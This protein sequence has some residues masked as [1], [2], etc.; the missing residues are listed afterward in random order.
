[1]RKQLAG[2]VNASHTPPPCRHKP[3]FSSLL[4]LVKPDWLRG[5]IAF[6]RTVS[7]NLAFL[8]NKKTLNELGNPLGKKFLDK[9]KSVKRKIRKAIAKSGAQMLGNLLRDGKPIFKLDKS[10]D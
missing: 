5:Q 3:C 6:D 1:D 2:A 8:N 7:K 4:A 10:H 9:T